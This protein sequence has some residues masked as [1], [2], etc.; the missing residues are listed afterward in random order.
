MLSWGKVFCLCCVQVPSQLPGPPLRRQSFSGT[1]ARKRKH[2][3]NTTFSGVVDTF[4][5]VFISYWFD[6]LGFIL[7]E[8]LLLHS[9]YLPLGVPNE[10][11]TF[12]SSS[13]FSGAVAGEV[14][15]SVRRVSHFQSLYFVIVLLN[16]FILSCLLSLSKIQKN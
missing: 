3:I 1:I 15:P 4:R 12:T 9:S 10:R 16:F 6:N 13:T 5:S 11:V 14:K 2:S 8:N 7:R